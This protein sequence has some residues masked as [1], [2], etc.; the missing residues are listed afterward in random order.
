MSED[1]NT[2]LMYVARILDATRSLYNLANGKKEKDGVTPDFIFDDFSLKR[3]ENKP[4]V[5][6]TELKVPKASKIALSTLLKNSDERDDVNLT[7][8]YLSEDNENLK[9]LISDDG[10]GISFKA[11]NLDDLLEFKGQEIGGYGLPIT[12]QLTEMTDM[13]AQMYR[14]EMVEDDID[15]E[16]SEFVRTNKIE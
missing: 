4:I 2:K 15:S 9:A 3:V 14:P 11:N 8:L 6:E 5:P 7:Y 16:Y 13:N 10:D 12:Y 1:L